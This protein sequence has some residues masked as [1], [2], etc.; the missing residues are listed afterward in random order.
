MINQIFLVIHSF[1]T[2]A[3]ELFSDKQFSGPIYET[4]IARFSDENPITVEGVLF[5]KTS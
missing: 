1:K 2:T 5:T 4:M 3:R